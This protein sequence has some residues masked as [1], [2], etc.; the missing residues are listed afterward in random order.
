MARL[1][2]EI[3]DEA[4]AT[5]AG[6][7]VDLELFDEL[8]DAHHEWKLAS[9]ALLEAAG[10]QAEAQSAPALAA[11]RY[12]VEAARTRATVPTHGFGA[13]SL[14]LSQH[15]GVTGEHR[16]CPGE[17]TLGTSRCECPCHSNVEAGKVRP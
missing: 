14:H 2:G 12:A 7:V 9:D 8:R 15:C 1:A 5:S 11:L 10:A 16:A 13:R 4:P 6:W 3:V 17:T